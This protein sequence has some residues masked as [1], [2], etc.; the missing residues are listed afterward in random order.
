[1]QTLCQVH[2]ARAAY[3]AV[4]KPAR[5]A[6]N[7]VVKPARDARDATIASASGTY[8]DDISTIEGYCASSERG[9]P[10]VF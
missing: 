8:T 5:D 1:M 4:V 3:N 10:E 2:K 6:Y 9:C 7:A